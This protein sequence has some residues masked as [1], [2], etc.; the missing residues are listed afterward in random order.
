MGHGSFNVNYL[1]SKI[2]SELCLRDTKHCANNELIGSDKAKYGKKCQK[3][4]SKG[5]KSAHNCKN[6]GG[7][8]YLCV[9]CQKAHCYIRRII[10]LL[11]VEL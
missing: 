11:F 3:S 6:R 10:N 7:S 4:D 9:Q 1:D 8:S 2:H 5:Y